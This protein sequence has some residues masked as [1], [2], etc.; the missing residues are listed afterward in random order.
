MNKLNILLKVVSIIYII[1]GVI[2]G[3]FL[4]I[5]SVGVKGP[6]IILVLLAI[7]LSIAAGL[8][9]LK[10]NMNIRKVF[11]II[12]LA[13]ACWSCV[14]NLIEGAIVPAINNLILPIL[15]AVGVYKQFRNT[16]LTE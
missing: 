8:V 2:L 12:L 15:Y 3:I 9:G 6:Y 5:L 10:G 7:I 16:N 4:L 11:A 14:N 13:S 1:L